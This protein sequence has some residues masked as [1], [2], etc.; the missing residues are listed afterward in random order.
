M[1]PFRFSTAPAPPFPLSKECQLSSQQFFH[2]AI[3]LH[4]SKPRAPLGAEILPPISPARVVLE[5]DQLNLP[6]LGQGPLHHAQEAARVFGLGGVARGQDDGG[7]SRRVHDALE[8]LQVQNFVHGLLDPFLR[9]VRGRSPSGRFRPARLRRRAVIVAAVA[10]V[11]RLAWSEFPRLVYPFEDVGFVTNGLR[12]L[13]CWKIIRPN[14]NLFGRRT[15][16][17][18]HEG[19]V[20]KGQILPADSTRD[21]TRKLQSILETNHDL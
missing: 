19:E 15:P 4:H 12:L 11:S 20:V 9:C 8:D 16:P 10:I 21:S 14:E 18:Q 6:A 1:Q 17:L 13:D 5:T 3:Q 7:G 2:E